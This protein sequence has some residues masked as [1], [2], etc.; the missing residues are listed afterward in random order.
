MPLQLSDFDYHLPESL[1]AQTPIK[2]RD[3]SKLLHVDRTTGKP[4]HHHF[5]ELP[6]LLHPTDVLVINNSKTVPMRTYGVKKTGGKIEVLFIKRI[7]FEKVAEVWEVLSSPGLKI[8]QEI[9]YLNEMRV[10]CI[11]NL[12]YTRKVRVNPVKGTVVEVLHRIGELPTP[13]YIHT[14]LADP[15]RYQTIYAKPEG[16]AA[17]PTAGLHFTQS[18]FDSLNKK[19]IQTIELTLHVGLGTFL[20][21][22]T[23][24]ITDH[25]MHKEWFTLTPENAVKLN[26][27]KKEG[28]RIVSVGT[29]TTRVLESCTRWNEDTKQFE[30]YAQTGETSAF[31]YPPYTFKFVDTLITNFHLPKSTLLMLL[32]AFCS[33]GKTFT[34]FKD[35][36]AGKAYAEAINKKYRFFSFGDAMMVV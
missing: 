7:A 26:A 25:V 14:H 10:E 21:V 5:F 13:H 17:T 35:S 30:L 11:E 3:H 2:Q 8:G 15:K 16:S 28:R 23:Q 36:L 32:S 34:T 19:G 27:F 18:I 20:P 1:I 31:F 22:K 6:S 12:G 9:E 4:T 24:N 29:T 33:Q